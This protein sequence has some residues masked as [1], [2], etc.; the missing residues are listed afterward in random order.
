LHSDVWASAASENPKSKTSSAII[1]ILP[2][3]F[4]RR[5]GEGAGC[6]SG[7]Y[8]RMVDQTKWGAG[9]TEYNLLG[10]DAELDD[11]DD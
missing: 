10:I 4:E 1:R 6:R 11:S 3:A 7:T 9:S 5:R 2:L 8:D